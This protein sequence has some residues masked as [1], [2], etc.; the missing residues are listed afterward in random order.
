MKIFISFSRFQ[1]VFIL[2]LLSQI[3]NLS[4]QITVT[5]N[6]FIYV[7]NE[8]FTTV[9]IVNLV[10]STSKI[11]LRNDAQLLQKGEGINNEG[12]G[13]ISVYQDNN[14]HEYAYNF[15]CSPVGNVS[16]TLIN[17]PF[18]I[19]QIHDPL[20]TTPSTIDSQPT[21]FTTGT[22]GVSSPLTIAKPWLNIFQ[23]GSTLSNWSY[24]GD[25]GSIAPGLGFTMKGTSGSN[26]NQTYDF[27]GKPNSGTI[28]NTVLPSQW[29]LIGNPYPSALDAL[30]LIH[31]PQNVA[32]ITGTLYFWQQ[33]LSILSHVLQNYVGGYA[34]YTV[35]QDGAVETFIPAPFNTYSGNGVINENGNPLV[36][37]TTKRVKRYLPIG[38]GFMVEGKIGSSG[39]VS[40]KNGHRVYYKESN[41]ESE[42]FRSN[43]NSILN[44]PLD[45]S[46]FR[47]NIDFNNTY[48]RQLVQTFNENA[49][50]SFDYGLESKSNNQL[51]NDANWIQQ[52]IGYASQASVFD[53]N[54]IL[55]VAVN[56]A[57]NS[58][59][60]FRMIGL[61][62]FPPNQ[63][64]FLYDAITGIYHDLRTEMP[65]INVV[66]GN[67][68]NRFDIRFRQSSLLNTGNNQIASPSL[69]LIYNTKN[70][71][72]VVSNQDKLFIKSFDIIDL[73]GKI[74]YSKQ[75]NSNADL[76]NIPIDMIANGL[77]IAVVK[78]NYL[79]SN[80]KIIIH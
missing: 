67:Y 26:S 60:R 37:L 47:L 29:T 54:L 9:G 12:L 2:G 76:I 65:E 34:S 16:N 3:T 74:I 44:L 21:L 62:N 79:T 38:Q 58:L 71:E 20:L 28:T 57:T 18:K 24:V 4:A 36:N 19:N 10:A 63:S 13:T 49:T 17:N 15:W 5:E 64:L 43:S 23:A 30:K 61:E 46:R 48:T 50:D 7:E 45:Y 72:I 53:V 51:S 73:S 77:Y 6:N 40:T 75:L 59:L 66:S 22:Q 39:S 70:K 56:L 1:I 8:V 14:V 25:T 31:D 35:T 33:D 32:A 55:P 69:S 27:R 41:S 78:T 80:T 52:N 11:Y 42:F 68:Q